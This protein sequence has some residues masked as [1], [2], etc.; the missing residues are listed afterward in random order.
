M[1]G[2]VAQ[3][4]TSVSCQPVLL[5][6]GVF[7]ATSV[8]LT[9]FDF[10]FF[11]RI[12]LIATA[13]SEVFSSAFYLTAPSGQNAAFS[14]PYAFLSIPNLTQRGA[15]PSRRCQAFTKEVMVAFSPAGSQSD[16]ENS[17]LKH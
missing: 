5:E 7:H 6:T 14:L 11:G 9:S 10:F 2:H 17:G 4:Y 15:Y 12:T 13:S 8:K 1:I 16:C 3:F